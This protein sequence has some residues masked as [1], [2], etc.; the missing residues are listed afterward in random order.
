MWKPCS[1]IP[2]AAEHPLPLVLLFSDG[3]HNV[4]SGPELVAAE[5]KGLNL[6][7]EPVV[8]AVAGVS[9]RGRA[10]RRTHAPRD[11]FAGMLCPHHQR[12]VAGGVHRLGRQ[13]RRFAGRR[14][15]EGHQADPE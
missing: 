12:P 9:G 14:R 3:E 2:N 13:F 11:R 5:I 1:S 8:I 6:D 4:G 10:A 7:G 15:R